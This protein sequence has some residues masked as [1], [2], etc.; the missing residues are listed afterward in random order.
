MS[1]RDSLTDEQLAPILAAHAEDERLAEAAYRE[2]QAC[3]SP[4]ARD[5]YWRGVFAAMPGWMRDVRYSTRPWLN[6]PR[7]HE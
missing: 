1:W 2:Q 5:A 6:R 7:S 3:E 4:E